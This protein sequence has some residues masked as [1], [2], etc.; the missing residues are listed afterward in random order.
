LP[1]GTYGVKFKNPGKPLYIYTDDQLSQTKKPIPATKNTYIHVSST[2][3]NGLTKLKSIN[4]NSV[5][6]VLTS[7]LKIDRPNV[8]IRKQDIK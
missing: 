1:A 4:S 7:E 6:W 5:M 2:P 8:W 3:A